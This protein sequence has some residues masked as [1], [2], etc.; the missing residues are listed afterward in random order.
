MIAV[1]ETVGGYARELL[2]VLV[3]IMSLA[4]PMAAAAATS[5][6]AQIEQPET[7]QDSDPASDTGLHP[8][9]VCYVAWCGV[10]SAAVPASGS[11]I[12]RLAH[13]GHPYPEPDQSTA[14]L[15]SPPA[16]GPPRSVA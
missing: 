8:P 12:L 2:A 15:D 11:V 16:V 3:A 5:H 1:S 10:C 14:G 4:A 7:L 13:S 6:V 9:K